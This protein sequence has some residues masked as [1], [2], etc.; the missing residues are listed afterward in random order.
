[1]K[2]YDAIARSIAQEECAL[3][4]GLIGD[5][6]M[7]L[8]NALTA[9]GTTE[10]YQVHHEAC[11]VAMADGYYQASGKVGL[12][13]ITCGPG[14]TQIGTSLMSAALN[15][16]AVVVL[17]GDI[18][19]ADK[20]H[21][22]KIDQKKF[23]EGCGAVFHE[24]T[25]SGNLS[26]EIRDAFYIARARQTAVVLSV[27]LDIQLT[28]INWEYEYEPSTH[29][30][31]PHVHAAPEAE[32]DR[33]IER[34]E[35]AERPVIIAGIGAR[36]A[37]ARDAI[38]ALGDH[39]GAVFATSM[40]AKGYF[41]GHR[42]DLG[43]AGSFSSAPTEAI[44]AEADFV[45]GIGAQLGHYTTEGGFL[46]PEASVARIDSRPMPAQL[47]A[48]P[49]LYLSGDARLTVEQINLKIK[50][51]LPQRTGLR[52]PETLERIE[53]APPALTPPADGGL[54]PRRLAMALS[55]LIPHDAVI[56]VGAGHYWGFFNM[57]TSVPHTVSLFYSAQLGAIGQTLAQAIGTGV[58]FPQRPQL[59]LDGDGSLLMNIQELE[60]AARYRMPLVVLL[61]ND[62]GF[63]AEAHKLR[64]QGFAP[65]QAQWAGSPDFVTL[66]RGFGG[67]GTVVEDVAQLA[68]ALE[69]GFSSGNLF[70]IDARVSRDIVSDHYLKLYF[71]Q[72]NKAPLPRAAQGDQHDQV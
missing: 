31:R 8:W 62:A 70:L 56:T 17:V 2:V 51:R 12:A 55:R 15:R 36:E 3:A 43:I 19:H 14:L 27:P 29:F 9:L 37:G 72:E 22:Q 30:I 10:I 24:V 33:L 61:W 59:V 39:I 18:S 35:Q 38:I 65:G 25:S 69:R 45:L 16:S 58:A 21:I 4:F 68:P 49:G 50:A 53:A 23:V 5:G 54:D 1:M 11:A 63:G 20:N 46:F 41:S 26:L 52:T 47:G 44:L 66:A 7:Y 67:D 71:G 6:N 28:D 48:L 60:T 57:Y 40:K 64:A 34:L 13:T 32:I 42:Y